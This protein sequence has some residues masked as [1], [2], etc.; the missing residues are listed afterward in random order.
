MCAGRDLTATNP[1]LGGMQAFKTSVRTAVSLR[2]LRP[3]GGRSRWRAFYRQ[4]G[5]A[6]VI[7]A[8]GPEADVDRRKFRKAVAEAER[9][10]DEVKE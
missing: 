10:L 3:R 8:I 1:W 6:F 4:I 7:A 5:P 2:E 9:R